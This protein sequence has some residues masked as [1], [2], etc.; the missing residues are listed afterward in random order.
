MINTLVLIWGLIPVT[1]GFG[2]VFRPKKMVRVQKNFRKRIESF[3]KKLFKAHR[4]SGLSFI[5]AGT[6]LL[7]SYFY[8]VWIFNAFLVTRVVVGAFFP[9]LFETTIIAHT[10]LTTW[11]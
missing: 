10:A 1:I 3:E 7:M 2:F 5:L 9:H 11:I 4:T 8:P 6:V